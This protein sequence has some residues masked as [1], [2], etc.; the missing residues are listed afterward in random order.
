MNARDKKSARSAASAEVA[1]FYF[2]DCCTGSRGQSK[3]CKGVR[4]SRD[5]GNPKERVSFDILPLPDERFS[6]RIKQMH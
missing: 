2:F 1:N 6:R 5:S 3:G 4:G